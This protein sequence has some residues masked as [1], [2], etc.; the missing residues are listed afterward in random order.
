MGGGLAAVRR[1]APVPAVCLL[2]A[3]CGGGGGSEPAFKPL[4]YGYLTPLRL[5][6][7]QIRIEDHV[8][9]PAGPNDLGP[10]SP[11][12]PDQA[13]QQM[14]KDRLVA[15]GNSGTAVFVIDGA[16]ITGQESGP[17]DGS[18][19]VHLDI[20]TG[21]G[22][23]AGY[24]EAHVTRNFV[25]GANTDNGGLREQLYRL[26][27]QMM[28]D[29]NVEFEYQLRRTLGDWLVDASGAP[30][31]STVEQ[32]SLGTP[33]SAPPVAPLPGAAPAPVVT[34]PG[35]TAPGAP[36]PLAPPAPVSAP[37]SV[38]GTSLGSGPVG[39]PVAPNPVDPTGSAAGAAPQVLSPPPG[40]LQPPAGATPVA[41]SAAAPVDGTGESGTTDSGTAAYAAP[42]VQTNPSALP[43]GT[44]Y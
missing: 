10:T 11:V 16:G 29:M 14:A 19:A 31:A 38:P 30:L 17:L 1:L 44:G 7:G 35:V 22:G 27:S 4:N 24:A 9:P 20:V 28:Q 26:T 15:A 37:V 6:V 42:P 25:P 23:H 34:A 5:N 43:S 21:S 36:V 40:Y 32:Q 33:G 41:P 8:P 39:T 12:P 3:A 18:M 13:L 2:L